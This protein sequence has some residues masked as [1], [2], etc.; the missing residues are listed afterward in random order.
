MEELFAAL[1]RGAKF[2]HRIGT[3]SGTALSI[4]HAE[5]TPEHPRASRTSQTRAEP[6]TREA[7]RATL[8]L[9]VLHLA[10]QD[11]LIVAFLLIQLAALAFGKGPDRAEC[12]AWVAADLAAYLAVV[13]LVRGA[14]L[15]WGGAASSLLY[16]AAILGVVSGS[17]LQLRRILPAVSPW[18]DDARI[19]W[20]DLHIFG[21]EPAIALDR[22][23]SPAATEWFSFFYFSYFMIVLAHVLPMLLLERDLLV[24]SRFAVGLLLVFLTAHV[25]YMVVPGRG[26][27][28]YL[29]AEFGHPLQGGAFWRLVGRAVQAGGA[30]KD[31]FP[32]LHTAVPT[33]LA[34]FS[35]RHRNLSPFKYTWGVIAFFATQ[36][37]IATMFLRWHY[38]VDVIAGLFLAVFA[39]V[40]GHRVANW[41][42]AK[43]RRLH[44]RTAWTPLAYPWS[45]PSGA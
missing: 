34:M 15:P 20:I 1:G 6:S 9:P 12:A 17:Y 32:S 21:A 5:G 29:A 27:Y 38:L 19:Y 35:F 8:G 43:R 41:E 39:S 40:A 25:L 33:Y 18:A 28:W 24:L 44:L 2:R 14:V 16:R 13:V 23:V 3:R 37:I 30:Q 22:Y 10:S 11:W 4:S 26:P 36:I 31:I 7:R 42:D 45:R